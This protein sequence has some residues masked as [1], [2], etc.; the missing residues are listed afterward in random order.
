VLAQPKKILKKEKYYGLRSAQPFW[1]DVGP[2][3]LGLSSAQPT[4][5]NNI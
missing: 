1:A 2:P 3:F 5:F 4:G